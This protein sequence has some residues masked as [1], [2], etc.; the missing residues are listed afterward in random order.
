MND[1]GCTHMAAEV[2]SRKQSEQAAGIGMAYE[3]EVDEAVVEARF[4]RNA[5]AVSV[6]AGVGESAHQRALG[7]SAAHTG[8]IVE[9]DS[10]CARVKACRYGDDTDRVTAMAAKPARQGVRAL[11]HFA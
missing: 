5:H 3:D 1:L 9:F 7:D 11:V 4:G 10:N 6:G 2:N 8:F